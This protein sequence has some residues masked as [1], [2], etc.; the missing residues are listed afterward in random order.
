MVEPVATRQ[1][2]RRRGCHLT[3]A[4]CRRTKLLPVW[5]G[6]AS[7]REP[8]AGLRQG[9]RHPRSQRLGEPACHLP[10][11]H[12]LEHGRQ[13]GGYW[14]AG[15]GKPLPAL[16]PRAPRR[17]C[18]DATRPQQTRQG[19]VALLTLI[20]LAVRIRAESGIGQPTQQGQFL[21]AVETLHAAGRVLPMSSRPSSL[22]TRSGNLLIFRRSLCT[23]SGVIPGAARRDPS[24]CT[25]GSN[26]GESRLQLRAAWADRH[27]TARG[28]AACPR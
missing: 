20:F 14:Q 10:P 27:T 13:Q 16:Q 9:Q 11:D 21:S 18:A 8:Q 1:R 3:A 17:H 2:S 7:R 12:S 24:E 19:D 28:R 15:L 5:L 26:P 22:P 23:E 25:P 4:D 6:E